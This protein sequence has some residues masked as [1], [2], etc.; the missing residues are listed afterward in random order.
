MKLK[1]VDPPPNKYSP[2]PSPNSSPTRL[3][4]SLSFQLSSPTSLHLYNKWIL[5]KNNKQV[6]FGDSNL[7]YSRDTINDSNGI[8]DVIANQ[9]REEII[10]VTKDRRQ[11][12]IWSYLIYSKNKPMPPVDELPINVNHVNPNILVFITNRKNIT[13]NLPIS[14]FSL[15]NAAEIIALSSHDSNSVAI[16]STLEGKNLYSLDQSDERGSLTLVKKKYNPNKQGV[17]KPISN[18][19]NQSPHSHKNFS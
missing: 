18:N 2:S 19:G 10:T 1:D 17:F 5:I 8:S 14:N 16:Y 6:L 9:K 13:L 11:F 7:M 12:R 4:Y 15:N 3:N